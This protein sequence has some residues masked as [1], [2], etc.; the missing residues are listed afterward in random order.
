MTILRDDKIILTKPLGKLVVGVKYEV[1]D[2]SDRYVI[3][4]NAANKVAMAAV[5]VDEFD[6]YFVKSLDKVGW[7]EWEAI[8]IG[9]NYIG[10]YRTNRKKVQVRLA[11]GVRA[12][13]SCNLKYDSFNLNKGVYLA[14]YRASLIEC[15]KRTKEAEEKLTSCYDQCAKITEAITSTIG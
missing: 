3:I 1:G 12:E 7:T 2:I 10:S 11:N 5:D 14:Y 9:D 15:K 4:R 6:E 8:F 13:A